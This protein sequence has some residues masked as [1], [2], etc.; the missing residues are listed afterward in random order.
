M[1]ANKANPHS[2][3]R[4][5]LLTSCLLTLAVMGVSL[6]ATVGSAQSANTPARLLAARWWQWAL[7]VPASQSPLT[8]Q[9]GQFATANQPH[10]AVW[11]LAG[12]EGGATVRSITVPA[13]KALFFPIVNIVDVED[14][15]AVGGG[16]MVFSAKKPLQTAQAF[17]STVIATATAMF[18]SVDGNAVPITSNNLEQSTPFALNLDSGNLFGVPAGV[19]F[20]AV[21]SGYYV[22]VQPLSPGQHTIHFGGT[23]TYQG[24]FSLDVTYHITVQ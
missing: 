15:V 19:Y 17:V 20:P 24:I 2:T 7:E 3:R 11:F 23:Q 9:T 8:D 18:C 4:T 5:K 1:K 22:L 13:G 6:V 10:G 12:N 21:D 16:G 14:G